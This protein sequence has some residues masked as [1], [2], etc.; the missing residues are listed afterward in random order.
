[1]AEAVEETIEGVLVIG[2]VVL[3]GAFALGTV[4]AKAS[5]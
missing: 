1:M 2:R 5:R 3:T 4:I